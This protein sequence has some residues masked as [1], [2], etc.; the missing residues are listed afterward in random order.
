MILSSEAL[1]VLAYLKSCSG[2]FVALKAISRQAGGRKRFEESPTW[3]RSLMG[4]LVEAALIEVNE[5]GQYRIKEH[6][7]ARPS[8]RAPLPRQTP[9]KSKLQRKVVGDDYFPAVNVPPVVG[10]NYFPRE[11]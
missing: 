7:Q 2:Q 1:E 6:G 10:D 3:A 9:A 11:D 4:P 5:R 8:P